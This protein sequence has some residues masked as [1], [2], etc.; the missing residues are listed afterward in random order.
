M[1]WIV[2]D[3]GL[4]VRLQRAGLPIEIFECDSHICRSKETLLESC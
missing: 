3:R 1:F 2:F 4:M